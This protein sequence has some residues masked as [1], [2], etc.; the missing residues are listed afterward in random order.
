MLAPQGDVWPRSPESNA[1]LAGP[2]L[3]VAVA[4]VPGS[5]SVGLPVD[6][7]FVDLGCVDLGSARKP[8]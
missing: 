3:W 8:L 7:A 5:S 6:V 1:T 4:L 2:R